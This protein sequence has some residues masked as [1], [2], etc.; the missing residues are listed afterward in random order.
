MPD[1]RNDQ[2]VDDLGPLPQEAKWL[3]GFWLNGGVS[4]PCKRPGAWMREGLRPNS[5]W[6]PVVRDLLASQVDRIR[7]W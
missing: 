7:H 1:V 6:G 4:A 3:I 2:T 5:K